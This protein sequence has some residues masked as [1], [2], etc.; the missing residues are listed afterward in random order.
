MHGGGGYGPE[1][2]GVWLVACGPQ[3]GRSC[4]EGLGKEVRY[5]RR[6]PEPRRR[7]RVR[8]ESLDGRD[9]RAS[10]TES[11]ERAGEVCMH[12]CAR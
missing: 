8:E 9:R 7:T 10:T 3:G 11:R 5:R 4:K 1:A 6:C 12:A 2:G